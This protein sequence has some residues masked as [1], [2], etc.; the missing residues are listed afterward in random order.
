M[1]DQFYIVLPSNSSMSYFDDNTTTHFIT[2]LPQHLTLH[3]SWGVA[4]TELQIPMTFQHIP[5][6][7]EERYV[8]NTADIS[9]N[10]SIATMQEDENAE[11]VAH[12]S[13][14]K[15]SLAQ[16]D[17]NISYVQPGI[18]KDIESLVSE[19][20]KL[21]CLR[22]HLILNLNPGGYVKIKSVCTETSCEAHSHEL[23]LSTRLKKILGFDTESILITKNQFKLGNRPANLYN[24]LPSM[25]MVYSDICEPIITGD[26]QTPLLRSVSL[27]TP[28]YTYGSRRLKN[29]SPCMYIPLLINSFSTIE[30]DIKDELGRAILFDYGTLTVTLHF[31]R[32]D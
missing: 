23:Q 13:I 3:G 6:E 20:N 19:L 8:R 7:L 26:V 15:Y 30:I 9:E 32:L 2:R 31:K 4:L 24:S 14:F 1:R 27:G 18:Y 11:I 22:D 12:P 25:L 21:D 29:F 17:D 10:Y 28:E 16:Q 5:T